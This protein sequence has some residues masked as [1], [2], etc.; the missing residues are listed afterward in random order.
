MRGAG[1][2]GWGGGEGGKCGKRAARRGAG[3]FKLFVGL[4]FASLI[5][6]CGA[7]KFARLRARDLQKS[8]R[9]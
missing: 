8:V 3:R 4:F 5:W 9:E 1:G 2:W 7:L 6:L